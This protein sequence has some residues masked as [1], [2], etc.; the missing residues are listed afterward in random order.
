MDRHEINLHRIQQ[1]LAAP[2]RVS[3]DYDLDPG[4]RPLTPPLLRPASV[5]VPLVERGASLSLILTRRATRLA[6]HPGQIA[7]P[8]GKRDPGDADDAATAL[9]E[10]REEIGLDP[11]DVEVLGTFD[12]HETVTLFN[13][14]PIVGLVAE[15]FRPRP[16][17]GEVDEVFE[18]PL[19]FVLDPANH[20]QHRR[21]W[22]GQWRTYYA[23]PFGPHY[24][25][26]ATARMIRTLADRMR[27]P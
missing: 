21:R 26:G 15:R 3:S 13:V 19:A 4:A 25:W 5:L 11:A 1:A 22:N 9:R 6:H 2:D 16:H 20:Q 24:I 18:V 27:A 10:A 8:G 7:F 17:R 23:I 14:T 12:R